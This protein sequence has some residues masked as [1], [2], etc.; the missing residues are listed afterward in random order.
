MAEIAR[1]IG[2]DVLTR[3]LTMA[4]HER[5]EVTFHEVQ[6]TISLVP[7]STSTIGVTQSSALSGGASAALAAES[8]SKVLRDKANQ[9]AAYDRAWIVLI[10]N[11]WLPDHDEIENAFKQRAE[12]VPPNWERIFV[13]PVGDREHPIELLGWRRPID[14]SR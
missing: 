12:D 6:A 1:A 10:D 9:A 4:D 7:S 8:V 13:L 14:V 3:G 11:D 2:N 5:H